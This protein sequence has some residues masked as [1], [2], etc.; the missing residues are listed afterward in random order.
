MTSWL[1]GEIKSFRG[2]VYSSI[3]NFRMAMV[4]GEDTE[5]DEEIN[6]D[7][8]HALTLTP[9]G[10][11]TTIKPDT[12]GKGAGIV[13]GEESET[14]DEDEP[15]GSTEPPD[16]HLVPP[17]SETTSVSPGHSQRSSVDSNTPAPQSYVTYHIKATPLVSHPY[18]ISARIQ[19]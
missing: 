17:T 16:V 13:A 8:I 3:T 15:D 4:Q 2:V 18:A 10:S 12:R 1:K 7:Q 9:D 19:F 14:D 6:T 11:L 5:S